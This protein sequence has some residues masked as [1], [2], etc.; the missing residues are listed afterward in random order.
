MYMRHE[1]KT[2][3]PRSSMGIENRMSEQSKHSVAQHCSVPPSI[4]N[5]QSVSGSGVDPSSDLHA[6]W[7]SDH[8]SIHCAD[9]GVTHI[10]VCSNIAAISQWSHCAGKIENLLLHSS[11]VRPNV[12]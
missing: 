4:L 12:L 8:G 9:F 6:Y 5:L 10:Y 2:D 3:R 11:S 1:P 7:Q